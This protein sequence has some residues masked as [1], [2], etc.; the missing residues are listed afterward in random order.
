MS[1]E[2]RV[3]CRDCRT[4]SGAPLTVRESCGPCAE[5]TAAVH[6]GLGHDVTLTPPRAAEVFKAYSKATQELLGQGRH[7]W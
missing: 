3:S 2:W 5:S 4:E 6:R 7:G 1:G